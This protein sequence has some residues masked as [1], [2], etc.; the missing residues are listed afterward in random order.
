MKKIASL[1]ALAILFA[2]CLCIFCSCS[3]KKTPPP[4]FNTVRDEL[5][6][7]IENS[8]GINDIFWG[9][10]LP[11]IPIGSDRADDFG[12]YNPFDTNTTDDYGVWEFVDPAKTDYISI[13]RI[14]A[15]AESAY[16]TAFLAPIYQAQFVGLYNNVEGHAINPHYYED[17]YGF[18]KNTNSENE[19]KLFDKT[20]IY[21]YETMKMDEAKS[22]GERI[23]VT[24]DTYLEGEDKILSVELV[25]DKQENGWYLSTPTC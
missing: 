11:V 2:L 18:W 1:C 22:S 12:L 23:F 24:V 6:E 4:D 13:E 3:Q 25:F 15:L 7:R 9:D 21:K 16:S 10:G 17:N 14:K 8:K 19:F 20:R 5:I